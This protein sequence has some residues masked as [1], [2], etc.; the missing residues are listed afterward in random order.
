MVKLSRRKLLLGTLLAGVTASGIHEHVRLRT[1]RRQQQFLEELALR[2]WERSGAWEE[3]LQA[4]LTSDRVSVEQIEAI[5]NALNLVPPTQP[6]NREISK[7]LIQCSRIST[8]QYLT[9][10]YNP[11]YDGSVTSLPSYSDRL[12]I[13]EQVA[14]IEGPDE[15]TVQERIQ[16]DDPSDLELDPLEQ[17]LER[18]ERLIRQVAGQSITISWQTIVYWGFALVSP[19]ASLIVFRGTQRPEEWIQNFL[20]VQVAPKPDLRFQFQGKVHRGFADIYS[21]IADAT[22]NVARQLPTDRPCYISGHSLGAAIATLATMDL[23]LRLPSLRE[24]LRLYTYAS[25]RIGD[26]EFAEAHSQLVPNSYRVFNV[27]D[28]FPLVPMTTLREFV[29]VHLGEDWSFINEK[30]DIGPNHLVSTYRDA[31]EQEQENL[32]A[33]A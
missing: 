1:Q 32:S 19:N 20:A 18:A 23:A 25:P 21:S 26:P 12:Q 3:A 9:G 14:S 4:A 15:A 8:E 29:F 24:Q 22:L 10:K 7:H 2:S 31:I 5:Q 11:D 6:Y 13:Y 33:N 16:V 30:G 28:A 27:A 17:N